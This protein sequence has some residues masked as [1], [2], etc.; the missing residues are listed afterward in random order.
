MWSGDGVSVK[1]SEKAPE[2]LEEGP[3]GEQT[4]ALVAVNA[5]GG[6]GSE[7]RAGQAELRALTL[8]QEIFGVR[9]IELDGCSVHLHTKGSQHEGDDQHK[10]YPIRHTHTKE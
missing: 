2:G 6:I 10:G 4:D 3:V 5:P 1:E 9:L 7:I 8:R